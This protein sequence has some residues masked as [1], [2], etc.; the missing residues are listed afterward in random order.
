MP[1]TNRPVP[2]SEG[3]GIAEIVTRLRARRAELEAEIQR[4]HQPLAEPGTQVPFGKRAGDY[5][6]VAA[7]GLRR[8]ATAAQLELT[9]AEV[10]RALAKIEAGTYGRCDTC[11]GEIPAGRLEVMPWATQCVGCSGR[12]PRR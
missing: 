3:S 9:A 10:S 11:Q 6:E 5:T 1:P 7:E 4:L 12:R 2:G 8:D